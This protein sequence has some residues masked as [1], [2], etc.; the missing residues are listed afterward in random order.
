MLR[1]RAGIAF[2]TVFSASDKLNF[3]HRACAAGYF[4]RIFFVGT[5]DPRINAARV[6]DRVIRGGHTVPI[7]KIVSR[8]RGSLAN[9]LEALR[10]A[11]R[12]YLYDNSLDGVGARL[13][14]RVTE[15]RLRKIYGEL[16]AWIAAA[17][18]GLPV[19]EEL[20]DL[21]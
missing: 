17:V 5:A 1:A 10:V 21:R 19:H 14:A 12:V 13:C 4:T 6:A 18:E 9:L 15:G 16:P 7:E 3:L 8:Y 20:V 2:K 11:D